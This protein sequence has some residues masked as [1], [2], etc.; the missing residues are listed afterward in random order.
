MDYHFYVTINN[1]VE[2]EDNTFHIQ[3]NKSEVERYF[4]DKKSNSYLQS[5]Y[6]KG[7]KN[8]K[9]NFLYFCLGYSVKEL[10]IMFGL[11]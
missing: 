11:D 6:N 1:D 10:D 5:D 3:F 4:E 9:W 8:T 2:S 7:Y